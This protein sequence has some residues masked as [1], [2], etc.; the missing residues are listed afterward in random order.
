VFRLWK[1]S[2]ALERQKHQGQL[3]KHYSSVFST[4]RF[5]MLIPD[6]FEVRDVVFLL[7]SCVL[8]FV[9]F[10]GFIAALNKKCHLI[11]H[12]EAAVFPFDSHQ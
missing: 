7:W 2:V 1:E 11:H 9:L 5:D 12:K 10:K 4:C 8:F 6:A 3:G